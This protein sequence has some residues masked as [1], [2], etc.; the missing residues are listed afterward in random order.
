MDPEWRLT[1]RLGLAIIGWATVGVNLAYGFFL[2]ALMLL[3]VAG[4]ATWKY[5]KERRA[6]RW[7]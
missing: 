4:W 1:V 2:G 7:Q 3:P 6:N 5:I